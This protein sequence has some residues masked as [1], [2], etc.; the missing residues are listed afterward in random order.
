[1]QAA[2]RDESPK[3]QSEHAAWQQYYDDELRDLVAAKDRDALQFFGY[4]WQA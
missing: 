1:M 4:G 2:I 3:N